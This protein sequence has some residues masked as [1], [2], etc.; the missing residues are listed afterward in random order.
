MQ[1]T[2]VRVG[3]NAPDAVI[4]NILH[5][6]PFCSEIL[7]RTV[8]HNI[9]FSLARVLDCIQSTFKLLGHGKE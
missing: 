3:D 6:V 5:W 9:S 2:V 4:S 1:Q 8:V 7:I